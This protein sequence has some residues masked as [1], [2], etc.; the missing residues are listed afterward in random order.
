MFIELQL[1]LS[2]LS[3]CKRK[4]LHDVLVISLLNPDCMHLCC[5]AEER[6]EGAILEDWLNTVNAPM[7]LAA[8]IRGRN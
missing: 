7:E 4:E 8:F 5:P 6:L 2:L 3:K 1:V